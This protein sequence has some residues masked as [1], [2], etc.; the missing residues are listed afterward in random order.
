MPA[1]A[2]S[3]RS[4]GSRPRQRLEMARVELLQIGVQIRLVA[5]FGLAQRIQQQVGDLRH[6][7]N[8]DHHRPHGVLLR[9]ETRGST[10]M[11]SAEPMLVPPNFI[12]RRFIHQFPNSKSV[13]AHHLQ[14]RLLHLLRREAAGVQILGVG[15]L[16]QRRFGAGAVALVAFGDFAGDLARPQRPSPAPG[17]GA[18]LRVGVQKNLHLRVRET[19]R[20]RC[21][22][23][24]S[25]TDCAAADAP[26]LL[27]HGPPHAGRDGRL[28]KPPR[29][30]PG[31]R[32]AAVTSSP[33]RSTRSPSNSICACAGQLLQAVHIVE[34][35]RRR[36]APTAP[37]RDTSR[38][39]RCR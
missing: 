36:A 31:S 21:R 8:H 37:P 5:G 2:A 4:A 10:R 32:M 7:R 26:L 38:R 23:P 6:G 14:D 9:G 27:A 35:D 25:P 19:P 17:G 20:F 13:C 29:D 15:R 3:W 34:I 24:P 30:T 18:H 1:S 12:T 11:R 39:C 33:F 16:R 22:G 28:W